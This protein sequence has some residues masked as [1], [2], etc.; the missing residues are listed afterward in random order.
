MFG[1]LGNNQKPGPTRDTDVAPVY[2]KSLGSRCSLLILF[3]MV[4]SAERVVFL[5]LLNV[6]CTKLTMERKKNLIS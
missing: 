5:D 1:H 4:M 3:Q 6:P 2:P